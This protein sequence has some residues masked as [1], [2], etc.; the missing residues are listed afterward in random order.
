MSAIR[1]VSYTHLVVDGLA[2]H[3]HDVVV[4]DNVLA[5][6]E[7]VPL[8]ALLRA[9]DDLVQHPVLDG[10]IVGDVDT[11]HE[12]LQP[13]AAEALHQVVFQLSLIHI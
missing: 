8:D 9:F 10:H 4:L 13:F 3:T 2:L 5:H 7:A 1:S 6:V 12:P 11:R